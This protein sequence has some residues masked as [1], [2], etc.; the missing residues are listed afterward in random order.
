MAVG[1]IDGQGF[2]HICAEKGMLILN[3]AFAV[4]CDWVL[5]SLP[6]VFMWRMQMSIKT[7]LGICT[8]MSLGFLSV[9]S[10]H[11]DDYNDSLLCGNCD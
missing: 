6:I 9:F 11:R 4:S 10:W 8:L 7:K 1:Y 5:A 2:L 3:I